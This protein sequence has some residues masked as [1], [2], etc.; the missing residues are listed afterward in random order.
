MKPLKFLFLIVLFSQST[1][2]QIH[3]FKGIYDQDSCNFSSASPLIRFTDSL[4]TLWQIGEPRKSFFGTAH[5]LP[6]AIMT[7]SINSYP[8]A[9]HSY[10]DM[11][12]PKWYPNVIV[13]FKHKFQTDSLKDGGYIEVSYDSGRNWN[14]VI[15]EKKVH[16]PMMFF[17]ENMYQQKDSLSGGLYGFSGT[18]ENWIYS[19]IQWVWLVPLFIHPPNPLYLRFHFISDSMP[20]EKSGW[21]M[22]DFMVSIADM[23][24]GISA[25]KKGHDVRVFP[26]PMVTEATFV[27][28]NLKKEA[29]LLHLYTSKGQL[30]NTQHHYHA[31]K[32]ILERGELVAGLYSYLIQSESGLQARGSLSIQ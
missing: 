11:V 32:I 21:I 4:N 24:T 14:N 22:D 16:N 13:S 17:V 6:Y 26:N 8:N 31:D 18:Q 1:Y 25:L 30:V 2:G 28:P 12:L 19:R 10:F 15:D 20:S 5:S 3:P 29:F 9:T 7:D 23:G 27:F